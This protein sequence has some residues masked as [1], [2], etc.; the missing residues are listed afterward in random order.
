M[1]HAK[2]KINKNDRLRYCSSRNI[3]H[4]QT[5]PCNLIVCNKYIIELDGGFPIAML[6]P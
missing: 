6:L 5:I 3:S 1:G 2:G 4:L